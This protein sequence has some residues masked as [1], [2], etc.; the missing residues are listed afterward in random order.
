M[1][2][3]GRLFVGHGCLVRTQFS[4]AAGVCCVSPASSYSQVAEPGARGGQEHEGE[5]STRERRARASEDARPW[6]QTE[7]LT[8][9]ALSCVFACQC[10][11][12]CFSGI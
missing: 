4:G 11:L 3:R 7:L 9:V 5:K 10:S 6:H 1:A 2:G 8:G 12:P